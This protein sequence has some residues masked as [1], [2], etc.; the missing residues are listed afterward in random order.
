M[1]VVTRETSYDFQCAVVTVTSS[2]IENNNYCFQT[3]YLN[4]PNASKK[5]CGNCRGR[6]DVQRS[7]ILGKSYLL[8]I[9]FISM[10]VAQPSEVIKRQIF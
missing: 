7:I 2:G 5:E 10:A 9:P 3:A 6:V 1:N 8:A 4:T